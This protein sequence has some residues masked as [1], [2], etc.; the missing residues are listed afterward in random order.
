[1]GRVLTCLVI[2]MA[3]NCFVAFLIIGLNLTFVD[4]PQV[5]KSFALASYVTGCKVLYRGKARY[6]TA[7]SEQC[8]R[9]VG[10]KRFQCAKAPL[11]SLKDFDITSTIQ[12]RSGGVVS[13]YSPSMD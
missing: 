11:Q 4:Y 3:R 7:P 1:M 10:L 8:S 2:D 13:V 6:G 12:C 5:A 9:H